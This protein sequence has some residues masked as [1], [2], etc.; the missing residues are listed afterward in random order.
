MSVLNKI[1]SFFK[2]PKSERRLI[3]KIWFLFTITGIKTKLLPFR[4]LSKNLS[5]ENKP[6]NNKQSKIDINELI[7]AAKT[8]TK[9]TF[10]RNKCL[11]QAIVI[12]QILNKAN[13]ESS[14][15][16]AVNNDDNKLKAHAWVE[17]NNFVIDLRR[18]DRNEF[19][20]VHSIK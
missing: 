4:K 6:D 5:S 17:V 16:L 3:V 2:K 19:K 15:Y 18:V 1:R 20:I 9:Y 14:F 11:E 13:I 8:A 12:K 7:R 10:T